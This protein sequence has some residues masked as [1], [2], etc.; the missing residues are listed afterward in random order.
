[1]ADDRPVLDYE[2]PE[3]PFEQKGLPSTALRWSA[4]GIEFAVAVVLFFLGGRWLDAKLATDPWLTLVGSMVG[5]AVGTYMLVRAA[6]RAS[7][8]PPPPKG[9]GGKG[10]EGGS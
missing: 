9:R 10:R 2:R 5:I 1:M 6:F 8:P 3:M 4:A 7:E